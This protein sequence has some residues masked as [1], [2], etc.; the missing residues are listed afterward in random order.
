MDYK[1]TLNL[2]QT[3]FP[4]KAGL[5][6][7][8][9]EMLKL[10]KKLGVYEQSI[11][12]ANARP[13]ILHDG[14][15]YA[16]G[17]IHLGHTLNK[18]LKDIV[19]KY[20]SL[21]G[22]W[23]P[24]VPG[25]DCHGQPIDQ[26]VERRLKGK[27][28]SVIEFR[29]LCRDYALRYVKRQTEEFERLGVRGDFAHP[30]L[31]LDREYEATVTRAFATMYKEGLIYRGLKPVHW[32]YH[33]RTALAE[34]EIEYADEASPSIYV[35]FPVTSSFGPLE[36]L[37]GDKYL[38]IWTT[39]PWTLPAN[40]AVAVHP[41]ESY[42]AVK[43]S[44]DILVMAS[45]LV[46]VVAEDTG[47]KD[48]EVV[49]TFS[50]MELAGVKLK[51][52][53]MQWES[54]VV[55]A[56]YVT[57]DTGTGA[58][59]IAP[60]HGEEDYVVGVEYELRIVM[61]VD[62]TGRFTE[63]AGEW[64]GMHIW[65]ANPKIVDALEAKGLLLG[66]TETIHSY[67]HCWRCKNP[68]IFR[69]TSQWFVSM[70]RASL[71]K[72]ALEAIRKVRWIPAKGEKRITA[73][74]EERPD[75]CI[76][77]QRQ[78][79]VPLPIFYC[80]HCDEPYV[81]DESLER[82]E[83]LFAR[84]GADAWFAR[85]ATDILPA[86]A[87]CRRCGGTAFRQGTDILDVW[88]ESGTS[89]EAVLKT[90]QDQ[91]WPAD[92]YLEGSDQH[93]GWFQSSLLVSV[94]VGQG[95]PYKGVLTH[96]FIVDGKGRKM[97]KSL[98]NVVDPLDVIRRSG[99]DI[100]RLW[101][102]SVDYSSPTVAFSDE[103]LDRVS[104]AY[105]RFRNTARF[106]LGNLYDFDPVRD[107]VSQEH[108]EEID[109]WAL[110][111]LNRLID[112]VNKAYDKYRFYQVYRD[113]YTF[114]VVD[115]SAFYLDVLKDRL[116]T[117]APDAPE[118]RS[119]QTAL[120][121]ILTALTRML[122]PILSFTA[123]EIW[124]F[125]PERFR[126]TDSVE[127]ASWPQVETALLDEELEGKWQA[128]LRVRDEVLKVLEAARSEKVVGNSLEAKV[129]LYARGEVLRLLREYER[130][131][132]MLMIV[133]QVDLL[134]AEKGLPAGA[135]PGEQIS[136][137]AVIVLRVGGERCDRCWNYRPDVGKAKAHPT[138]CS[139]CAGVVGEWPAEV[140]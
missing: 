140:E 111:R 133:S 54:V 46:P 125:M 57:L 101:T 112:D 109:R 63:E 131:L 21:R 72:R 35:K 39:T 126:E 48:Y 67:P 86:S 30:Y 69:A 70:E 99:A 87:V 120:L 26:Q 135:V 23:A 7:R 110:L 117:S 90:R 116:Y 6:Q 76:S 74:V 19:V 36:G 40:V 62:D 114:C 3:D 83:E 100:L 118:R 20:K 113:I 130:H 38:V 95:A 107:A 53:L 84:E 41:R 96:G 75:W 137:L 49:A 31:T 73:M 136:D 2:P 105:R 52:P 58:V 50:G 14:P 88:F 81:T 15:P 44:S 94:G 77:R 37:T 68:V 18:V 27:E 64:A 80:E 4:M 139:L 108:L 128:L 85:R 16:N 28:V 17:D 79:G 8:E 103:I 132:P 59:H 119:A 60:G 33:D 104:E 10:W 93:R 71:R 138:L 127:L 82:I 12:N 115:L 22:F 9:P 102:A 55:T 91:R 65:E 24:Y 92:L 51:Q 56:D 32:C 61:P 122:S 89:H 29:R 43:I 5:A 106:L 66:A 13:F 45:R 129:E 124:Q 97:S 25:W 98:G 34:A 42:S 1:R 134:N 78:W 121:Q 11:E 123:E 47:L